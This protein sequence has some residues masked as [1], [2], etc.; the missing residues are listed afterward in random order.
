MLSRGIYTQNAERVLQQQSWKS[1]VWSKDLHNKKVQT[2]KWPN[3]N[4]TFYKND[5]VF[6]SHVV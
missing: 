4:A 3:V 6:G 5:N 1:E 2:T